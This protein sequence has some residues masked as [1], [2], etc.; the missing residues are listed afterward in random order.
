MFAK[1][2]LV[3]GVCLSSQSY[4]DKSVLNTWLAMFKDVETS[5]HSVPTTQSLFWFQFYLSYFTLT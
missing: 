4:G 3:V 2:A 5:T 1:K